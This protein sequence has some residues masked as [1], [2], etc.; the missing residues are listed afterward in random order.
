MTNLKKKNLEILD[1]EAPM[2]TFQMRTKYSKWLKPV[3][4]VHMELR[5]R[6]K[7]AARVTDTPEDWSEYRTVR[8]EC[9]GMQRKDRSEFRKKIFERAKNE[10]DTSRL[11]SLTMEML[12][13]KGRSPPSCFLMNGKFVRKQLDV[14][15]LQSRYYKDKVDLIKS[16][17]PQVNLDPLD[18]LRKAFNKWKPREKIPEFQIKPVTTKEVSMMIRKMKNSTAFGHD[19]LNPIFIK[20]GATFFTGPI[21]HVINSSLISGIFSARWKLARIIPLLK[22]KEADKLSPSSYGPVSQLPLVS[23]LAERALQVQLLEFLE[24]TGQLSRNH[25][26]YRKHLSTSSA[27]IQIM[28]LIT[29]ATDQ[30]LYTGTLSIDQTAA[31]DCVNHGLLIEKLR[32]YNLGENCPTWLQSYLKFRTS[33]VAIGSAISQMEAQTYGFPQGSVLGP[34]LYLLYMNELSETIKDDR[35]KDPSHLDVTKLFGLDCEKIVC[36][37]LIEFFENNRLFYKHQYGFRKGHSTEHPIVHFTKIINNAFINNSDIISVFVDLHK[38]FDTV[39]FDILLKKLKHYGVAETELRW[40]ENY[41]RDRVQYTEINSVRSQ[42]STNRTGVPQGSVA[43]P[44]LFLIYIN[45]FA[46]ALGANSLLFA[47]DT[48]IQWVGADTQDLYSRASHDFKKA[49]IWFNANKLT[50]NASKTKFIYYQNCQK[51]KHLHHQ[52]LKFGGETLERIGHD[53]KT[54]VFK[55]LGVLINDRLTWDDH[56]F[57]IKKK[58]N[59]ANYGLAN[60]KNYLPLESRLLVYHSLVSSHLNYCNLIFGCS[61]L[62]NL[63][64]LCTLQNKAIRHVKLA[65]YNAHCDQFY[66]ELD[67]LKLPDLID[68]NRA[69]F[70]FKFRHDILPNSFV[71]MFTFQKQAGTQITRNSYGNFE[72]PKCSAGLKIPHIEAIKVW[73]LLPENFKTIREIKLFK[74]EVK[75]WYL[76]KYELECKNKVLYLQE[77]NWRPK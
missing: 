15:N 77:R 16:T 57:H 9:I 52:D 13:W 53:C 3:T 56:I 18:L 14:A 44:L 26:V 47:D 54:K 74:K 67:I 75:E 22:S 60:S 62:S 43:G 21:T 66:R 10:N 71:D 45:D 32:F 23:K 29:T 42:A 27:V 51:K 7:E 37:Q 35:C 28:D 1:F 34:L 58:I 33:Y 59:S 41:L 8:T 73:N 5:D 39:C 4:K 64:P 49:E 69:I 30:N 31:F 46:A 38:A 70:M 24:K 6:L 25:H 40:F 68:Y 11:F 65:K 72:L 50:L 55:F 12:S 36:N 19:G 2:R 20:F 61:K 48:T 63:K 17:L 76:N